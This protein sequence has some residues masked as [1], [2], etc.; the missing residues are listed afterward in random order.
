MKKEEWISDILEVGDRID[1]LQPS[2]NFLNQL[3]ATPNNQFIPKSF[4]WGAAASIAI[5]ISLNISSYSSVNSETNDLELTDS[6]FNYT[7]KI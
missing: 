1:R 2:V 6:F 3:T 4:L 5:L 7:N